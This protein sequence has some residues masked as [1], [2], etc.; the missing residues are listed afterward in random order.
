MPLHGAAGR[1]DAA[2]RDGDLK[3][4]AVRL[5]GSAL[6]AVGRVVPQSPVSWLAARGRANALEVRRI[7]F[8]D[9]SGWSFDPASGNLQHDSGR[10]FTV[11]G[12][13]VQLDSGPFTH[14]AQPTVNQHDIGVLG[15]LIKEFDGVLHCLMQAKMEPG[16]ATRT[17]LCPTVQATR[18]NYTGV[19]GG[20]A[21]PYLKY[22]LEPGRGR[23][24]VDVLQSEM[25]SWFHRKRNR[26]MVVEVTEDITPGQ[27]FRWMTLG[28]V[29]RLLRVDDVVNMDVRTV[30]ACMPFV[31]PAASGAAS[32][33]GEADFRAA[34][35]RALDPAARPVHPTHEVISWLTHMKTVHGLVAERIPLAAVSGWKQRTDAITHDEGKYF[36]ILAVS[37]RATNREVSGWTQP[38][39]APTS[40]GVVAFLLKRIDGVLHALVQARVEGGLTDGVELGPTVQCS[41]RNYQDMPPSGMPPFLREVLD[42]D[43]KSIRY[44]VVLSDEGGRSYH[45]RARHLLIEVPEELSL[46]E[47]PGFRWVAI[48]QLVEL[49]RHSY[50]VNVQARSLV[51][52]LHSLWATGAA[53]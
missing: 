40:E 36:R 22:F 31:V 15:I 9:L 19:H 37:V 8:A 5:T 30:L 33:T 16:N 39:I 50:Y 44:D 10:F 49:L 51:A 21:V 6:T 4:T 2:A 18:S 45:S 24:L 46:S 3:E 12:L 47:L 29:F 14:W 13:T 28:E 20:S 41:P 7:D 43:P 38:L 26:N 1:A 25:G 42:A 27:D 17:Q 35:L 53:A 34:L 52:A 11:E 23:V 32:T 48:G